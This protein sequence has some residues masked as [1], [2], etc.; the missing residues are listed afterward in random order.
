M[1]KKRKLTEFIQIRVSLKEKAFIQLIAKK[2]SNK[3]VS[4]LIINLLY[5]ELVRISI[6]DAEVDAAREEMMKG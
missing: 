2:H 5:R 4:E 1:T 6:F 3:G